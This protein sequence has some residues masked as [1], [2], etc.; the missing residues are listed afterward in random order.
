MAEAA[1][2]VAFSAATVS[3]RYAMC[4]WSICQPANIATNIQASDPAVAALAGLLGIALGSITGL[5][6][7]GLSITCVLA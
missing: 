4:K 1:V 3:N 2:P 7:C 6:G 5:V